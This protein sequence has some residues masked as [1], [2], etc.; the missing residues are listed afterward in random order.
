MD[1]LVAAVF[2]R[3]VPLH[4]GE[5]GYATIEVCLAM[6]TSAQEGREISLQRKVGP[7]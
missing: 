4:G 5:R 3:K 2:E 7:A 6:Q 1:E